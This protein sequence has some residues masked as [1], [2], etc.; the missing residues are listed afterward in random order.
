MCVGKTQHLS[1]QLGGAVGRDG[2]QLEVVFG[3]RNAAGDAVNGAGGPK[4]ELAHLELAA[5]L[6]KVQCAGNVY[7]L[8]EPRVFDGRADAGA[9]RQVDH[10]L[11][12]SAL[13]NLAQEFHLADIDFVEL[14]RTHATDL[15]QVALLP[16]AWIKVIEIVDDRELCTAAEQGLGH[17]RADEASPTCQQNT[18]GISTQTCPSTLPSRVLLEASRMRSGANPMVA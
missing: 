15:C 7:A 2:A 10:D 5:R 6:Q 18:L 4:E 16:G 8:I 14:K 12:L 17:M 9:R 11:W 3:K 1:G 13:D